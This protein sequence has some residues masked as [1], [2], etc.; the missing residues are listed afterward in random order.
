[1]SNINFSTQVLE[2][3]NTLGELKKAGYKPLSI[4]Q[5]LRKNL[6][7][8]IQGKENVFERISKPGQIASEEKD[9]LLS[10][11]KG[12]E[13]DVMTSLSK[14]S[15]SSSSFKVIFPSPIARN[16]HP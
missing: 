1:M 4:R 12:G 11:G 6:V 10:G 5:E 14:V 13:E 15:S 7:S 2:S 3:I 8:K 16:T 9:V